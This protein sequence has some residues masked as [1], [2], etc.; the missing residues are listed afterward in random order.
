MRCVAVVTGICKLVFEFCRIIPLESRF[1]ALSAYVAFLALEKP[2]II[3]GMW[4]M[5]S[6]A[7]IVTVTNK[8][9]M[10]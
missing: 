3:A 8:M 10:G 5:A 9:I 6:R 2:L 4:R 1:V 7:A